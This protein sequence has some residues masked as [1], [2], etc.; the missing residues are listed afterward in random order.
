VL[1]AATSGVFAPRGPAYEASIAAEDGSFVV[2]ARFDPRSSTLAVERTAGADAPGR[3]QELWVI[4]AGQDPVSIG[5]IPEGGTGALPID[6][7]VVPL[8]AGGTFAVTDEPE[9]GSPSGA[10]TGTL[11]AAGPFTTL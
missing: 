2:A 7:E 1:W 5:V 8:L 3:S 10:P 9:G 6:P 11:L 4:P